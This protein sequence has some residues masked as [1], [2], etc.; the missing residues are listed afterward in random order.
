MSEYIYINY[1]TTNLVNNKIYKGVHKQDFHFPVLFDGYFGSGVALKRAI[2]KYG[3][4]NFTRETLFVYY[5]PEEAY[6]KE[7]ELINEEFIA[8]KDTY[9]MILGGG[10]HYDYSESS[11][12]KMSNAH[13][14]KINVLTEDGKNIKVY[15]DDPRIISGEL[16]P[17]TTKGMICV[18]D[19]AGNC[20]LTDKNDLRITTGELV[21]ARKGMPNETIKGTIPVIDSNGNTLRINPDDP[22]YLSG[23]LKH[24]R[25]GKTLS[26]ESRKKISDSKIGISLSEAHK[27]KIGEGNLGSKRSEET[28]KKQSD[29][30]KKAI[31]EKRNGLFGKNNP[32]FGKKQKEFICPYCDHIGKAP[33]IYRYHFNNCKLK[34]VTNLG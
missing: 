14:G 20:F 23:E 2:E 4:E 17:I 25:E 32:F 29:S 26:D 7:A 16:T 3:E 12:E 30:A 33:N 31:K 18:R 9:N 34:Q 15:K 1:R 6:A 27:K 19:T 28:K 10:I 24:F 11:R 8:R 21:S 13:K 5:T 22:R